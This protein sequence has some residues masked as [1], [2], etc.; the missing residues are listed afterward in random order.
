MVIKFTVVNFMMYVGQVI[1]LY[2]LNLCS[3]LY[4]LYLNIT[5][6]KIIYQK[7]IFYY[8][9]PSP[10][11]KIEGEIKIFTKIIHFS[12]PEQKLGCTFA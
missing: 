3:A 1:M 11:K 5:G 7:K 9:Y 12:I 4:Q 6:R 2:T 10:Q 8:T